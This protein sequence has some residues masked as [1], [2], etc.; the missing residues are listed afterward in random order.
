MLV[1]PAVNPETSVV[2]SFAS[3]NVAVPAITVHL[4]TVLAPTVKPLASL[5]G[6]PPV[7]ALPVPLT[8]LHAP[9]P[10]VGEVAARAVV[11]TLQSV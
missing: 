9:I 8:V 10:V 5:V 1:A 7:S 3:S 6:S 2:G 11:V 4:S